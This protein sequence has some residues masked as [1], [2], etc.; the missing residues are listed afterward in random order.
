MVDLNMWPNFSKYYL[1]NQTLCNTVSTGQLSLRKRS[2]WIQFSNFEYLFICQFGLALFLPFCII[3]AALINF[4]NHIIFVCANKQMRRAHTSW[5]I[6]A[7]AYKFLGWNSFVMHFPR[8]AMNA[9]PFFRYLKSSIAIMC[10]STCPNPTSGSNFGHEWT[11]FIDFGPKLILP[12]FHAHA[13]SSV[14]QGGY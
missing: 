10:K 12:C 7:M 4:I 1:R 11:L 3:G 2:G 6:A 8:N 9:F 13:L 14:Q 5:V